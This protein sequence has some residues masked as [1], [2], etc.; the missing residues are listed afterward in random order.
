MMGI[1][2]PPM[3]VGLFLPRA[4]AYIMCTFDKV[5]ASSHNSLTA[6]YEPLFYINVALTT[7]NNIR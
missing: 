2:D 1:L 3:T 7:F 5:F 4:V 6:C